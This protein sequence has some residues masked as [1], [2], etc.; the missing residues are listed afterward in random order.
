MRVVSSR[1]TTCG[2]HLVPLQAGERQVGLDA[3]ADGGQGLGEVDDVLVLAAVADLAEARVVAVL[4]APLGVDAGGLE[5]AVFRRADPHVLPRRRNSQ[6]ADPRDEG[7]VGDGVT[8]GVGIG[9][10]LL[11]LRRRLKPG[12]PSL[13]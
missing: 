2:Q 4:L 1:R 12:M 7:G 8:V 11:P 5:V 3:P 10:G 13:T 9:E 6:G